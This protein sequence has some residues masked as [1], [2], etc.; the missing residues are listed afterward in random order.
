MESV[1][2]A[3]DWKFGKLLDRHLSKCLQLIDEGTEEAKEILYV[4][5]KRARKYKMDLTYIEKK[6]MVRDFLNV[7]DVNDSEKDGWSIL[8]ML[9]EEFSPDWTEE[10]YNS[11]I[12]Y[13]A[14]DVFLFNRYGNLSSNY[15]RSAFEKTV[16]KY[17]ETIE[18]IRN[19]RVP[20]KTYWIEVDT[21]DD[22]LEYIEI[23]ADGVAEDQYII[24]AGRSFA[25][26]QGIYKENDPVPF[27]IYKLNPKNKYIQEIPFIDQ[28]FQGYVDLIQTHEG[29]NMDGIIGEYALGMMEKVNAINDEIREMIYAS[30]GKETTDNLLGER[31]LMNGTYEI[32]LEWY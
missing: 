2:S 16:N 30:R 8:K 9:S 24:V 23:L 14:D 25:S 1:N 20:K 31:P 26:W 10:D 18:K 13:I 3:V 12:E 15:N 19:E 4:M 5:N 17:N 11:A 6:E 27:Q 7:Y 21:N 28:G 32:L 22:G 29:K